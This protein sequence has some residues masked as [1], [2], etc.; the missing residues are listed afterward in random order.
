MREVKTFCRFCMPFC[1]VRVTLDDHDQIAEVRGDK[2]DLM[3]AGYAC[4]K[5]LH[6]AQAEEFSIMKELFEE[7]PESLWRHAPNETV[8]WS[9]AAGVAVGFHVLLA[10][11][12]LHWHV[13]PP[14]MPPEQNVTMIDLAPLPVPPQ[15]QP[16]VKPPEV[17]PE[18]K[19]IVKPTPVARPVVNRQVAVPIPAPAPVET[20]QPQQS[21]A[22]S[23][24][25]PAPP[26]VDPL[27]NFRAQLAAYLAHYKRYPHASQVKGEEG[28]AM[29]RFT[30]DRQG[31]VTAARIE[32]GSGHAM[33]DDEVM[34]LLRRAAPLPAIPPSIDA[35]SLD[36]EVP[37][38]FSLH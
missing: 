23:T 2:D 9:A 27:M 1:G 8:R 35:N 20:A 38:Q 10:V 7:D 31:G 6:A 24:P 34:A 21:A 18:V 13:A 25:A 19:P 26:A 28:T 22:P 37:V 11:I 17:K 33:L 15:P 14:P 36:I 5:G 32:Q 16:I 12:L 30:L 4:F 3:T 29:V